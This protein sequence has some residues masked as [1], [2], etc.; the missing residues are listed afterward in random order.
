MFVP[1]HFYFPPQNQPTNQ[2]TTSLLVTHQ[3]DGVISKT[4]TFKIYTDLQNKLLVNI[5]LGRVW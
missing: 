4:T 2:P 3:L 5:P 1:R